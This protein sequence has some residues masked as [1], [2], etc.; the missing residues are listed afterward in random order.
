MFVFFACAGLMCW[1]TNR[2]HSH[3]RFH[4]LKMLRRVVIGGLDTE[5]RFADVLLADVITSYAKVLG[6]T[7]VLVC[8]GIVT[9]SL[10]L[11]ALRPDRSCGAAVGVPLVLAIPSLIRL[12]QCLTDWVRI[13]GDKG[14]GEARVHLW[15]AGKYASAF[16]VIWLSAVMREWDEESLEHWLSRAGMERVWYVWKDRCASQRDIC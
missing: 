8:M 7:W 4:F 3:G 10:P 14:G 9:R 5:L 2:L 13:R 6:D 15:N 12:R 11:T 16:P 1:P